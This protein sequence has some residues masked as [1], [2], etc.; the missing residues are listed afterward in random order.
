MMLPLDMNSIMTSKGANNLIL[1]KYIYKLC[2]CSILC[3]LYGLMALNGLSMDLDCTRITSDIKMNAA[4]MF[5][6][7]KNPNPQKD[8]MSWKKNQKK[9]PQTFTIHRPSGFADG[10]KRKNT[11]TWGSWNCLCRFFAKQGNPQLR[12]KRAHMEGNV[13]LQGPS[14]MT[15]RK[16]GFIAQRLRWLNCVIGTDED[17][18]ICLWFNVA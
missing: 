5:A 10:K 6:D 8:F 2:F 3:T 13:S 14:C 11:S 7:L 17:N 9:K 18:Q 16:D 1:S 12:T 4:I 15:T